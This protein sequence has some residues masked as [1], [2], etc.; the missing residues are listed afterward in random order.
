MDPILEKTIWALK[1]VKVISKEDAKTAERQGI[2]PPDDPSLAEDYDAEG[3]DPNAARAGSGSKVPRTLSVPSKSQ[4]GSSELTGSEPIDSIFKDLGTIPK[5]EVSK[6]VEDGSSGKIRKDTASSLPEQ[7]L[8]PN[9]THPSATLLGFFSGE[10]SARQALVE[11]TG[12]LLSEPNCLDPSVALHWAMTGEL[13]FRSAE[14]FEAFNPG[15]MVDQGQ[16]SLHF[17]TMLLRKCDLAMKDRE[18]LTGQEVE[19]NLKKQVTTWELDREKKRMPL[20]RVHTDL[21]ARIDQCFR[22]SQPGNLWHDPLIDY[23]SDSES[24]GEEFYEEEL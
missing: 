3:L 2:A 14:D 18:R 13:S 7:I 20:L 12:S 8:A 22:S 24:E 4:K 15:N 23:G 6:I 21:E 19:E 11:A 1:S 17:L 9:V 10:G 16:R 5:W